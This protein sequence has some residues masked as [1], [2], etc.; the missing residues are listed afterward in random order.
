MPTSFVSAQGPRG[1][2][3]LESENLSPSFKTSV[4]YPPLWVVSVIIMEKEKTGSKRNSFHFKNR[5]KKPQTNKIIDRI[6][7]NPVT[8][9]QKVTR[10]LRQKLQRKKILQP[11]QALPPTSLKFGSFNINGL[12]LET[13]WAVEELLKKRGFDVKYNYNKLK[14]IKNIY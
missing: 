5:A 7:Y 8:H 9:K 13:C 2:D 14:L 11:N 3:N 1:I 10:N 4:H 6:T 12:D